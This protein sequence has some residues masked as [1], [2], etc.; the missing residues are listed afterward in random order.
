MLW[1]RAPVDQ[2]LPLLAEELSLSE[3][4]AQK[5]ADP[6]ALI[7]GLAGMGFTV[8]VKTA[9]VAVAGLAQLRSEVIIQLIVVPLVNVDEEKTAALLPVVSPFTFH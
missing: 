9:V 5:V 7:L 3:S 8:M 6:K 4:P 1:L 2:L